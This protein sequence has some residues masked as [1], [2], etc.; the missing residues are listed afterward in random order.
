LFVF[1]REFAFSYRAHRMNPKLRALL[2]AVTSGSAMSGLVWADNDAKDDITPTVTPPQEASV[3]ISQ[4]F[5]AEGG[6]DGRATD[7]Q[8]NSNDGGVSNANGHVNYV[9]SPT[10]KDG[11]LLRFGVDAERNSFSLP[12]GAPLP[13]TLQSINAVIGADMSIGDKIL[14]RAELHPGIYSDF[15][16]ITGNDFDCPV[17]VG[18]TYLYSKDFQLILGFEIDL[19]SNLPIIGVPGFRWHFADN[20]VISAIPPKPR[21]EYDFSKQLTFYAGADILD[22][23]YQL[24]S[25]FGTSHGHGASPNNA[26]FNNNVVDFTEIRV[27]PG[28]VWKFTPNMNLDVSGGWMPYRAYDIHPSQIGFDI[29]DTTFKNQLSHGAPYVEAGVSGSF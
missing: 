20:W 3:P 11:L 4:E 25:S 16:H 7:R 27:G 22:G 6:W 2:L 18:G 28:V 10:I 14:M 5:T 13:N 8:G 9:V 12:P 1:I 17:Q 19:K 29:N 15:V 21:I 26:Q 23:T 24:N